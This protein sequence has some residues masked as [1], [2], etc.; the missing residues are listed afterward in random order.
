MPR[1]PE[2]PR[3]TFCGGFR[4]KS[5]NAL[6]PFGLLTLRLAL[7]VIFFAH[8]YPKLAHLGGGMQGFFIEHGLPG[9]FVYIAGVLEVFG[10]L[11]LMIGLFTRPAALL[12][13][14]EMAVAIWKVHS[15]RGYLAVHEYEFPLSLAVACF[16]L[17]TIGAGA[18]SLD[19]PLF[20]KGGK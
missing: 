19:Q 15:S 4:M 7:G 5:L 10:G 3:K 16:A 18:F 13:A 9:Y 11:L 2:K 20:E 14:A 1:L 8:G 6:Q 17:A 12:L